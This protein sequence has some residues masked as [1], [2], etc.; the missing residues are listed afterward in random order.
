MDGSGLVQVSP[1]V[2]VA[3]KHDWAPD[4][5]H[6]V[7][8]D[9]SEPGPTDAVNIA[10]VRPDGTGMQ[11]ITHRPRPSSRLSVRTRRTANGSS[12]DS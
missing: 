12:S 4:G 6:L 2:S 8:S 10:I 11:Y 9:N 7:F 3:Y 1:T 5:Q